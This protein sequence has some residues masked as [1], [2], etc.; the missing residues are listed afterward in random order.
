MALIPNPN[1]NKSPAPPPFADLVEPPVEGAA[2]SPPVFA[3][4]VEPPPEKKLLPD[5]GKAAKNLPGSF[6]RGVVDL[7]KGAKF[8]AEANEKYDHAGGGARFLVEQMVKEMRYTDPELSAA[9]KKVAE[10]RSQLQLYSGRRGVYW[11][12]DPRAEKLRTELAEAKRKYNEIRAKIGPEHQPLLHALYEDH[13]S[14]YGSWDNFVTAI[15]EDP[16]AI[17]G[18]VAA[19]A[20]PALRGVQV[21]AGAGKFAH[22][23]AKVA[24]GVGKGVDILDPGNIAGTAGDIGRKVVPKAIPKASKIVRDIGAGRPKVNPDMKAV[25][26]STGIEGEDIPLAVVSENPRI[27]R[28]EAELAKPTSNTQAVADAAFDASMKARYRLTDGKVMLRVRDSAEDIELKI[29]END[30]LSNML[31]PNLPDGPGRMDA[32]I[33][34]IVRG[35]V[36]N[37][38]ST[39]AD[40]KKAL[41]DDFELV[42]DAVI[43]RLISQAGSDPKSLLDA[44]KGFDAK[45]ADDRS[46]LKDLIGEAKHKQLTDLAAYQARF[47]RLDDMKPSELRQLFDEYL[48]AIKP[49]VAIGVGAT[50]GAVWGVLTQVA[51]MGGTMAITKFLDSPIGKRWIYEAG[52]TDGKLSAL[53]RWAA[54]NN[55]YLQIGK[56]G[57]RLI[58]LPQRQLGRLEP[59]ELQAR[60]MMQ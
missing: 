19:L 37:D 11:P 35:D 36:L 15:E 42:T 59:G 52:D 38:A 30:T 24:R 25:A 57:I 5:F 16:A 20:A 2:E 8:L 12:N 31:L 43:E 41:G 58:A 22:I 39:I 13:Q 53:S 10:I 29:L 1:R 51:Q 6:G 60:A 7:A 4:L 46:K 48:R 28:R 18:D 50:K 49:L 47:A 3:E 32:L 9:Y 33:E 17:I 40:L 21:S 56:D 34:N 27:M 14:K 23:A 45:Y 44:I 54:E 26:I 55:Q